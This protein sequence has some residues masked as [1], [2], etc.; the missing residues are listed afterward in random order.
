MYKQCEHCHLIYE[1]EPGFFFGAMFVSYI[2]LVGWFIIWYLVETLY[3]HWD[4][5]FFALAMGI[6]GIFL[7]PITFRWSRMI[8]LNFFN[9]YKKEQR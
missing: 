4:L 9:S 6:S 5:L 8:W 3:L 2:L 1:R 7:S